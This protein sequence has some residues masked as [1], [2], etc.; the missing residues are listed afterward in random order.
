[1]CSAI[2]SWV[3]LPIV[4]STM[5]WVKQNAKSFS[6]DH[7]TIVYADEQTSGIGQ[8]GRK[9]ISFRGVGIYA[10]LFFCLEETFPYLQNLGQIFA[11]SCIEVL[12]A[13]NFHPQIKWPND[14]LLN[15]KKIGGILVETTKIEGSWGT[16]IGIG[17][18]VNTT[19]DQLKILDVPATSLFVISNR[20]WKIDELLFQIV[21]R[22]LT[23]LELLKKNGFFPFSKQI[24]G[25]LAYLEEEVTFSDGKTTFRA[26]CKGIDELGRLELQHE[27]GRIEHVHTG[28]IK[29]RSDKKVR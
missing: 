21:E 8:H 26:I 19:S 13:L 29:L 27:D 2:K 28:S 4:D 14:L 7:I 11:I 9:W 5:T 15:G 24:K 25:F 12:Q 6:Q 18:N 22:F 3:H 20:S 16:S 10:T 23:N 17:I 1:M